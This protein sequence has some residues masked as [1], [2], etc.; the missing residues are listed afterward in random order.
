MIRVEVEPNLRVITLD[1]PEKRNALLPD[2]LNTMTNAVR[3]NTDR[4]ILLRAEGKLF[5]AGFDLKACANDDESQPTLRA[6]LETLHELI[7]AMKA[8]PVP[9]I[10][11]AHGAAIAGAAAMLAAADYTVTNTDA[12]IGYPVVRVGVSPAISAPTL[13]PR[14][15]PGPARARFLDAQLISGER[16]HAIGLIDEYVDTADEVEP[17]A[18]AAAET[19]AN[20]PPHAFAQTKAWINE[21]E[22]VAVNHT[23][24]GAGIQTSLGLLGTAESRDML[25]ALW[26]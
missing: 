9:V 22:P 4:A 20:K 3:D 2:M 25:A 19:L 23:D 14:I 15:S 16:A 11:A 5:S 18:R 6:L 13:S 1:R 12:K 7:T 21:L 24:P 8:A 10:I 26:N 17:A